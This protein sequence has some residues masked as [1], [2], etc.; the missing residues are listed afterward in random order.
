MIKIKTDHGDTS[1]QIKGKGSEV[2]ADFGT[3]NAAIIKSLIED[4][5][6]ILERDVII[7]TCKECFESAV[8]FVTDEFEPKD[9]DSDICKRIDELIA[10]FK[11]YKNDV[12]C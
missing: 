4:T 5:N 6:S 3:I 8:K 12:K 10:L 11:S 9:E 2:L 7:D 1:V